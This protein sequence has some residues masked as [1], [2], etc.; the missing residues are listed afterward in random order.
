MNVADLTDITAYLM[1]AAALAVYPN[2]TGQP[3]VANMDARIFEGWPN[4]AQLDLDLAG[5]ML[6]G[7]PPMPINRPGGPVINVSVYP[8]LGSNVEPFQILDNTY[9]L[10]APVIHMALTLTGAPGDTVTPPTV[11]IAGQPTAGEYLTLI[12]DRANIYSA[13]GVS[14][15]SIISQLVTQAL[16]LYP[17]TTS[18]A[19]SIT[20]PAAFDFTARQGAPGTIGHVT[21]RQK[22]E[23]MITTWAPNHTVRGV[24]AAAIDAA[25]KAKIIAAM[26]DTSAAKFCYN[27]TNTI[28]EQSVD[29]LY[30][31]DLIYDV[32]YATLQT[33]TGYVIT[34]TTLQIQAGNWAATTAP[35]IYAFQ[36]RTGPPFPPPS[37]FLR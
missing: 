20:I 21:H 27:R 1:H 6:G 19:T 13:S 30:R 8:M 5:K 35:P 3:S 29:T 10:I 37:P 17:G 7:I 23:I 15:A 33:F 22:Q 28:D 18:T 34:S 36:D 9:T 26:S 11:T 32:E 4:S 25:L 31:R 16:P 2:G 14:T 12:V 24:I